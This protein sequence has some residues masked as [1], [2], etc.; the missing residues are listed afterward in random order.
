MIFWAMP[1]PPK[2]KMY[3][4]VSRD[5]CLRLMSRGYGLLQSHRVRETALETALAVA[6]NSVWLGS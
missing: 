1:P 6:A 5:K 3:T 4:P 2:K